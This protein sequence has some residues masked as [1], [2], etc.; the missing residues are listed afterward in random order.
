MTAASSP[1][2]LMATYRSKKQEDYNQPR[3]K[4]KRHQETSYEEL[5]GNLELGRIDPKQRTA[6]G[7][8][9]RTEKQEWTAKRFDRL[10][11]FLGKNQ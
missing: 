7:A 6:H 2:L 4:K 10:L 11:P 8:E 5:T 3:P 9:R 1:H